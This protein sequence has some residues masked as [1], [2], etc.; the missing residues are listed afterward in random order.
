M[1]VTFARDPSHSCAID[2]VN[3]SHLITYFCM[4]NH[5]H[6]HMGEVNR[7]FMMLKQ[8]RAITVLL[9]NK[10]INEFKVCI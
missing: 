9:N 3:E 1:S 10:I 8:S 5:Q 7:D 6:A 4:R 2:P